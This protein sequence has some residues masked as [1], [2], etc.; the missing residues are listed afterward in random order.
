MVIRPLAYVKEADLARY[1]ELLQFPI[2]PCDLC[3]SQEDLKR[4]QVKQ[5]LQ[6]WNQR[7]QDRTTA[8]SPHSATSPFVAAGSHAL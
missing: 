2:I 6:D 5:M 3:G 8:C 7:F 4:K 1:A